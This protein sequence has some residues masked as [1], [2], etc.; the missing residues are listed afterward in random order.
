MI[1]TQ[2][3][4]CQ[5]ACLGKQ[6][7]HEQFILLFHRERFRIVNFTVHASHLLDTVKRP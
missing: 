5:W 1:G 3:A 7:F 2:P 6:P 4:V